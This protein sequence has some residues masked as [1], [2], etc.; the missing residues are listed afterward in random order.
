MDLKEFIT[1]E[2]ISAE[3]NLKTKEEFFSKIAE[4]ALKSRI[5][6]SEEEVIEGLKAR[7][8]KGSTGLLDGFAIPHA[9]NDT[10]K[11][12]AVVIVKSSN[13]VEWESL[14]EQPVGTAICLLVPKDQ[15]GTTHID[16]LTE[17][18]RLLMD[19]EFRSELNKLNDSK[20]IYNLLLE[21]L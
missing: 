5:I 17:V 13:R 1:L 11:R 21:R 10:I 9:Q 2:Q 15:A 4:I 16:F 8:A 12:A 14:D 3:N 18:S 7:E 6:T 20:S 19:D